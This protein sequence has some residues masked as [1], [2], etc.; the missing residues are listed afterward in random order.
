[1]DFKEFYKYQVIGVLILAIPIFLLNWWYISIS[2]Y[3]NSI[4]DVVLMTLF[5][6]IIYLAMLP[7]FYFIGKKLSFGKIK[8][9]IVL[10]T[11]GFI[12]FTFIVLGVNF[13]IVKIKI[14]SEIISWNEKI[15]KEILGS[16]FILEIGQ[17][18]VFTFEGIFNYIT[19]LYPIPKV[20]YI[21][22]IWMPLIAVPLYPLEVYVIYKIGKM[23]KEYVK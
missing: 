16:L 22:T 14:V 19:Y 20:F 5:Y 10:A 8:N 17:F 15:A 13:W 3:G 4:S 12:I 18:M 23:V 11:I 9:Y 21:Y 6:S 1:M 2:T 7:M